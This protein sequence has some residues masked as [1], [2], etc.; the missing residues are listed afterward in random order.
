MSKKV[1]IVGLDCATPSILFNELFNQLPNL[2]KMMAKGIFGNLKS[3]QP[4]I[5]IPAWMVMSTGAD[6]GSLGLYGFRHRKGF[7]YNK[8]WIANAKS[9]KT[10][11]MW[12]YAGEAGKKVALVGVPP[13][14]PPK[15]VNG[16][17]ISCFITPGIDR[18]YTYPDELQKEIEDLVG[19]YMFDVV[20]RT[21]DRDIILDDLFKMT[22]KR[23]KVIE[24]LMTEKPW[25][26]FMFVE[27]GVDRV[28]HAFWKYYD[29]EHPKYEPG[30]KYESVIPDYY[31][32][33]DSKIGRLLELIDDD[34]SVL[35]VSDH[36]AKGM[37]G[38]FCINQWLM[39]QGYLVLKN[40]PNSIVDVE[41][42]EVDWSKTKA[43]GWG[44]Y[45]ARI[46]FNVRGRE[47]GGIIPPDQ[48]ESEVEKLTEKIMAIKDPAG[49]QMDNKV[50]KPGDLYQDCKGDPPDLMVYFDDL[51]WRSA[52]T[53]GHNALYLF[54]NDTGPDD[55]VH[56][57]NGIFILYD[58]RQNYGQRIQGASIMD[59]A[60]TVLQLMD[61]PVPENMSGRVLLPGIGSEERGLSFLQNDKPFTEIKENDHNES[62][63][64]LSNIEKIQP[65]PSPWKASDF[66]ISGQSGCVVW[67]TGLS[68]SGKTT[69]AR[70]LQRV[71][72]EYGCQVEVLDGDELRES[73]SPD[74][75]FSKE[76]REQHNR[77][78]IYF[79]KLLSRNGVIVIVPLISPYRH[80]RDS[81]REQMDNYMEIWV[82]CS[83]TACISRDPKGL[84]KKALAGEITDM[85][86]LQDPYE[87]PL[88]PELILETEKNSIDQCISMIMEK[89]RSV[90]Y[91]KSEELIS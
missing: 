20:F 12:D 40:M 29:R 64:I 60:P 62:P 51:R 69:L 82:K 33:V 8:G 46:F 30:N 74:L 17:L 11:T 16:N 10:K 42:A 6:P 72:R 49:K 67:L 19:E 27:I 24:H 45:Y 59:V 21:E 25:D 63:G 4:P 90:G 57:Y 79:S 56:D 41:R 34:T 71:L 23:F 32:Y 87:E 73:L 55:A 5:T 91:L 2:S 76:D 86:G 22:D 66:T 9:V 88:C 37:L 61:L 68:G 44:G 36:G 80:I 48:F 70:E 28:H 58:P 39:E 35:V 84:Y 31:S 13:S 26:M 18:P 89:M 7:A 50:F 47:P 14:Y 65:K 3:C 81:A 1:L 52:G 43:W 85:T 83:L 75:G 53:I 38:C 15:P 77:R 54:E 78:V